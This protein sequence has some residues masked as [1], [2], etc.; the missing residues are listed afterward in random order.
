MRRNEAHNLIPQNQIEEM[1]MKAR[2]AGVETKINGLNDKIDATNESLD[3]LRVEWREGIASIKAV[4][5]TCGVLG[6]LVTIGCAL[7]KALH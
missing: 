4:V 1:P 3:A 5:S 6:S 2:I 7:A